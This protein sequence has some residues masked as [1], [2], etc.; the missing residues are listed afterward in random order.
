ME[1]CATCA[2]IIPGG[3]PSKDPGAG[4]RRDGLSS[5]MGPEIR[6]AIKG[7]TPEVDAVDEALEASEEALSTGDSDLTC[8]DAEEEEAAASEAEEAAAPGADRIAA[9]AAL[10]ARSLR[11]KEQ[12][13]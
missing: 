1:A 3:A 10:A 4:P 8:A 7:I 13:F 12:K 9:A 11:G 2:L 6:F 5:I